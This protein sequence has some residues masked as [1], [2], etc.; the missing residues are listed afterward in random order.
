MPGRPFPRAADEKGLIRSTFASL[1]LTL[2]FVQTVCCYH[3]PH[4][5]LLAQSK[6]QERR[7]VGQLAWLF[8]S[9]GPYNQ[10][11]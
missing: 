7:T 1:L 10:G 2:E 5:S 11:G 8:Q 9:R 6:Q 3:L 4:C